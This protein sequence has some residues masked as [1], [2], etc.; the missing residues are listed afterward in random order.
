MIR[1]QQTRRALLRSIGAGAAGGILM[2]GSAIAEGDYGNGNGIGGF[3]NEEALW[4]DQP[5]WDTGITDE[6]EKSA[7]EI[8]VGAVTSLDIP[9]DDFPETPPEAGPF[10]FDPMVV[11]VSPDTDVTWNWVAEH[12]SVTSFNE[13]AD[14]PPDPTTTGDHGQL[15]DEHGHAPHSVTH[16]FENVG[17]YLYFCHPHGTPYPAYDPFLDKI[18]LDPVRENLFGMRGA[19]RV[20]DE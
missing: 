11:K 7:V 8:S 13:A 1:N 19:V 3:L 12:H 15:F 9:E 20:S 14:E 17:T 2:T 4:K 18:G 10:A 6:T 5:I 16:T